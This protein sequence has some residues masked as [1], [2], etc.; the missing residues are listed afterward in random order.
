MSTNIRIRLLSLV[1]YFLASVAAARAEKLVLV[2]GGGDGGDG[3][4]AREAKLQM[5]FGVDFDRAGN[6]FLVEFTG[7]RVRKIDR[8]GLLSTVAG[9]GE[10]GYSGDEGPAAKAQFNRMH[11]LAVA[12]NGDIY[13]AD[14]WNNRVRKIDGR[15]GAIRTIAGTGEKGFSGDGGPATK[16]RFGGIYCLALDARGEKLYLADLD[17]RRIRVVDVRSGVVEA[18]AGNGERGVPKDGTEARQAPL[19]DPRAVAVDAKGNVYILE[20][21]GHALRVVDTEGKIR[22]VAG[23]GKKGFRGDGGDALRAEFNGP[24]HLCVDHNGDVLIADTENHVIRKYLPREGKIRRVAGTGRKGRAGLDGPPQD[25][26]L[27]QPHGVTA[28]PDGTI[29]IADSSNNRIV[30]IEP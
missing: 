4:P 18:V 23:T 1:I 8:K 17:N 25:A 2:A 29:Y 20:R 14:T 27:N 9:T 12:A 22:T 11:R 26:E 15:T 16:A 3:G 24:K 30:K 19:V 7:H 6:L 13:V 28:R 5:P 10:K 21:A